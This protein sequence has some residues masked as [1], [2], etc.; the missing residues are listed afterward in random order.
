RIPRNR[1][2]A[3]AVSDTNIHEGDLSVEKINSLALVDRGYLQIVVRTADGPK[4]IADLRGRKVFIGAW[5][6][7]VRAVAEQVCLQYGLAVPDK[8][9]DKYDPRYLFS[10]VGEDGWS[11]RDAA[12]KLRS[13]PQEV[14]AAFFLLPLGAG[15][16]S[17]LADPSKFALLDLERF[18]QICDFQPELE[19]RVIPPGAYPGSEQFPAEAIHTV[20]T[21][22]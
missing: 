14:D 5:G 1:Q 22:D 10:E 3:R 9:P 11:F 12:E 21:R 19:P 13:S 4:T 15:A 2:V 7:G 6:S 17:R 18:K 16:V 8:E 20:A